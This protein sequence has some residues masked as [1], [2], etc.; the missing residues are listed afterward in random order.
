MGMPV[1]GYTKRP[2]I[3]LD[4]LNAIKAEPR[5]DV[6][7]ISE[8]QKALLGEEGFLIFVSRPGSAVLA[9]EVGLVHESISQSFKEPYHSRKECPAKNQV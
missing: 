1:N 7:P 6:D 8:Y 4:S 2:C 9:M 5:S 3:Y